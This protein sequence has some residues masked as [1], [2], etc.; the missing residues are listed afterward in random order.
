VS[1]FYTCLLGIAHVTSIVACDEANAE[2]LCYRLKST[3]CDIPAD[4][5]NHWNT[6]EEALPEDDLEKGQTVGSLQPQSL[7]IGQAQLQVDAF[8]RTKRPEKA[9]AAAAA[10]AAV[11]PATVA[12]PEP[13]PEPEPN[14][15]RRSSN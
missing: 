7:K 2:A 13:E 11:V 1:L 3:L 12:E 9:V 8:L 14:Q 10:A 15:S 5:Q 4:D 6:P